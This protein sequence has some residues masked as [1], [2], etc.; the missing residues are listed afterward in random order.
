[1]AQIRDLLL[2]LSP[3]MR[4]VAGLLLVAVVVGVWFLFFA[5]WSGGEHYLLGGRTFNATEITAAERAFGQA[6]L[7][8]AR[9]DG[10]RI[11]VPPGQESAYVAALA[12]EGALP[13]DFGKILEKT[14]V[15]VNPFMSPTQREELIK[16]ARERELAG[17][18]R[19]MPDIENAAVTY[20]R[21]QQRGIARQDLVTASVTLWPQA[22]ATL[23]PRRLT[24][25]RQLVAK[26]IA[27]LKPD[28]V[29]VY[30]VHSGTLLA[31]D[32]SI[33]EGEGNAYLS[34]M[35]AYQ[36]MYESNVLK[37][38]AFVPNARVAATVELS[39]ELESTQE[40]KNLTDKN[41]V[42]LS[43][44]EKTKQSTTDG[45]A[46]GGGPPGLEAQSV[47]NRSAKVSGGGGAVSRSRSSSDK[48]SDT[49]QQFEPG[50]DIRRLRFAGLTPK[51]VSVAVAVPSMYFEDVWRSEKQKSESAEPPKPVPLVEQIE[52]REKTKISAAVASALP[53]S[54]DQAESRP[55]VT[56]TSFPFVPP[57]EPPL[58]PV[59]DKTLGWLSQNWTT[60]ALLALVMFSL[61][62]LRSMMKSVPAPQAAPERVAKPA[63][64]REAPVEAAPRLARREPATQSLRD[65]LTT[66]VREDPETAASV[67]R[68][69]IGSTG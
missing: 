57:A 29:I 2:S 10:N 48:T 36:K 66:M 20:D 68:G 31:E 39:K 59:T 52:E 11:R 23:E 35:R 27:G 38:L 64:P 15:Q 51:S 33:W 37:A 63:E 6:G 60:L 5:S 62:M 58:P 54:D 69:W 43:S 14:L 65:Q 3:A 46:G 41:K 18:I 22:G 61:L 26:A 9:I 12:A 13:D 44:T 1:M 19:A 28:D 49:V 25:I 4:F 45:P 32:S 16:N 50:H 56:V 7:N 24:A 30:D 42:T 53:Q 40:T 47:T 34:A 8:D 17:I 55:R 21:K 67:I